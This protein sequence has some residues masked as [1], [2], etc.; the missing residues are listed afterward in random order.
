MPRPRKTRDPEETKE[1]LLASAE[2]AFNTGGF[3][4][5]DTNRIARAAGYAP[6]TFYRHF[7]DKTDIFLAVY[8][9]WW[10]AEGEA[11]VSAARGLKG[12]KRLAKIADTILEFHVRWRIFRRALRHLSADD[13]RVR[14][15]RVKARKAQIESLRRVP[16]KTR[17]SDEE[18][19]AG[20]IVI[21]RL[22]D[23]AAEE[24]FADMGFSKRAARE[25]VIAMLRTTHQ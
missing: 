20:L 4:G 1:K 25:S 3:F 14:A 7:I 9:R 11:V 5:T 12:E 8:E 18:I 22:S 13:K 24:E 10:R 23:A 17:I 16:R 21:E 15:A 19:Y 2:R 6:Q